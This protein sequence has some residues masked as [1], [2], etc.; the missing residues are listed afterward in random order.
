METK[1]EKYLTM[2]SSMKSRPKSNYRNKNKKINY[3]IPGDRP[4][5]GG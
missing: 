4:E 3:F 1:H 5:V 2:N